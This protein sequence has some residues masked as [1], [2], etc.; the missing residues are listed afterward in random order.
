MQRRFYRFLYYIS[1]PPS[2]AAT[3]CGLV[4]NLD[5]AIVSPATCNSFLMGL[6]TI[7]AINATSMSAAAAAAAAIPL[8]GV[9][10]QYRGAASNST[11]DPDRSQRH[12]RPG[13]GYI[14]TTLSV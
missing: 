7:I 1:I 6:K 12:N 13:G 8:Q 4:F 10:R 11:L 9:G 2:L 3:G 5:M 14:L